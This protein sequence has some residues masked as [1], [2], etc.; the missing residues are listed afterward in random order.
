VARNEVERF[1]KEWAEAKDKRVELLGRLGDWD[2]P[3]VLAEAQKYTRDKDHTVAVAAIV[4]VARQAASKDKAGAALFK[5]FNGDKRTNVVCAS[6]VGMGKLGY[7]SPAVRKKAHALLARDTKETFRAAAR[8]LGYVK[9][10][11]AFRALAEQLDEPVPANPSSPS[12]P[13][14]SYW[15]EKW[16]DWARNYHYVRWAISELVPGE[17]F[18]TTKEAQQWAEAHGKEHA[19]EW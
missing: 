1:R 4:A 18:E 13:P 3:L 6:L 19:I 12:N 17:T 11:T 10:K 14:A 5:T 7:D 8:Y 2:H 9:D 15:K 16:E